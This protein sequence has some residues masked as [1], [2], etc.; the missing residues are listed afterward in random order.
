[1]D[2]KTLPRA[3]KRLRGPVGSVV[4]PRDATTSASARHDISGAAS[5][6]GNPEHE[7]ESIMQPDQVKLYVCYRDTQA[8]LSS[9][10]RCVQEGHHLDEAADFARFVFNSLAPL[11]V[12][13]P[14][15]SPLPC[16][17]H[18]LRR[19][20]ADLLRDVQ[21]RWVTGDTS[22]KLQLSE[23]QGINHKLSILAA[24]VARMTPVMPSVIFPAFSQLSGDK[25]AVEPT[26]GG[27]G[28][29]CSRL[30]PAK[31]QLTDIQRV[32]QACPAPRP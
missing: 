14:Q 31:S 27:G 29:E 24:H 8:R 6:P 18:L 15:S 10:S 13:F 28:P 23:L 16:D 1:V 25:S 9:F 11:L 5:S 17:G 21:E 7:S 3:S 30:T 32:A 26:A 22:P 12:L 2:K 4:S 20:A 19:A